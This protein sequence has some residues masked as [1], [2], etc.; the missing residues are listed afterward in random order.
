[1]RV[2]NRIASG[3]FALT[4]EQGAAPLV[5]LATV[6]EVG[7]PSGTY[8]DRFKPNGA[9]HRSANTPGIGE[10]L[11]ARSAQLVGF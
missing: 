2:G 8:F 1:M 7:A 9:V 6:D 3:W 5:H 11:W 4:P 10:A